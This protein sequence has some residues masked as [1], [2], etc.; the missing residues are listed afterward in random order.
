MEL[1]VAILLLILV[2]LFLHKKTTI[3]A[4][5]SVWNA[6]VTKSTTPSNDKLVWSPH[7]SSC[8]LTLVMIEFRQHEWFEGVMNNYAH[9]YGG[10]PE[11]ALTVIH[12]RDNATFVRQKLR[13]WKNVI[14]VNLERPAVMTLET[15]NEIL[16]DPGFWDHF[17]SEFVLLFQTDTLIRKRISEEFFAYDYV[18]APWHQLVEA[19]GKFLNVGN[20]GFSLRRVA[21]M[22]ETCLRYKRD[23]LP[24]DVFFSRYVERIPSKE[25][26]KKFSV[27]MVFYDNPCGMHKPYE[28][29][30]TSN[31]RRLLP[32]FLKGNV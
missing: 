8:R 10:Q 17:E 23:S 2:C 5:T 9:V 15:Y 30:S 27:E 14:F 32:N 25:L 12:G 7:P 16:C 19:H 31:V 18:G 26:A 1:V 22:K 11:V 20:G 6:F 4:A 21:S 3:V 28:Y 29:Q 13:N 24:E